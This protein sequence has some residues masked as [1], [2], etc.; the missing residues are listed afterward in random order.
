MSTTN[1]INGND[2]Q[3]VAD[4]LI[5][6]TP[7]NPEKSTE[8]IVEATDDGQTETIEDA[9][10]I[11]D[12]VEAQ[13]NGEDLGEEYEEAEQDEIQPEPQ[14]KVKV[15]G[16]E[17]EVTLDELQRGYSGQ[18]YI[19]KG[20][21]ENAQ[22]KKI[23]EQQAQQVTQ[24]RQ[25]LQQLVQQLK[26]GDIPPIPEYPSEELRASDPLGYLEKEADYRRALDKR[27]TFE[28]Q[29]AQQ[30]QKQ[31]EI[32]RQQNNQYLEQQA[33]RLTEWMPEFAD[34]EKRSVFI[35]DMSM[36]AKKHYDLTDEQIGTV[37]TAEEVRILN[38]A[39]KW[40]ELQANKGKAQEKAEG[41]RPMVK[42]AAKRAASSG[43]VSKAKKAEANMRQRGDLD[44]VAA[45]LLNP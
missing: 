28:Y 2:F 1:P 32:E 23:L 16:V 14:Y 44:S 22:T 25:T 21:A 42:S 43:K 34:P 29:L 30:Q 27:Q 8:Q 12:D 11:Q 36:K 6:E 35:Q 4:N 18:K 3:A 19:Q 17:T 39:L 26:S 13:A 10:E 45:Y 20:M 9:E 41:A 5:M 40:R 7:D 15:D 33:Q 37:K 31:I 38:D 24:E